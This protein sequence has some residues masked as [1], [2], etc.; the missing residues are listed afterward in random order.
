MKQ[1]KQILTLGL[2]AISISGVSCAKKGSAIR[3]VKQ[4]DSKIMNP[5]VSTPSLQAIN[6]QGLKY[7]MVSISWPTENNS[8]SNSQL[9]IEAEIKTPDGRYIPFT[10]F[11]KNNLDSVGV[12]DDMEKNGTKIDIRARCT[13]VQNNYSD[14]CEKYLLL[15][16]V[17]KGGFAIHQMAVVSYSSDCKFNLENI[18]YTVAKLYSGLDDLSQRNTATAQNDRPT[19]GEANCPVQ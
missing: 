4:T 5:A 7:D 3:A 1:M 13:D 2:I 12:I 16:T 14:K 18:N 17:V 15:A 10:T 9:K 11:H 19:D 6:T 8:D